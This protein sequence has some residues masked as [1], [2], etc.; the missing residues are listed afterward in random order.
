MTGVLTL[1]AVPEFHQAPSASGIL[2][3]ECG[4]LGVARKAAG[5][6]IPPVGAGHAARDMRTAERSTLHG[7]YSHPLHSQQN[8]KISLNEYLSINYQSSSI[9]P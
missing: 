5:Q 9:I 3:A 8:P 7:D 1:A 6:K 2:S 4:W